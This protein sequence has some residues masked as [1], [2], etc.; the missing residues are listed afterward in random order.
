MKTSTSHRTDITHPFTETVRDFLVSEDGV[1]S[2]QVLWQVPFMLWF[3]Y[4]GIDV[5][6]HEFERTRLQNTLDTAVLAAA[7][8]SQ[9]GDPTE[10][11]KSYFNAAGAAASLTNV[12]VVEGLNKRRV[13]ADA[14]VSV[15]T[16]FLGE[17]DSGYRRDAT[18]VYNAMDDSGVENF[19]N[20]GSSLTALASGA[21]E[22]AVSNV[23][24]SLVVDV[25]GSM[26]TNNKIGK[27]KD[28]AEEFID[29]VV[30][31]GEEGLTTVSIVP[32][33][34]IVNLGSEFAANF[35][36]SKEHS[37][38]NC[39][40]FPNS[41]FSSV[42]ISQ[43]D[44]I[45][46]L[47]H[48][49]PTSNSQN[50]TSIPAPWCPTD[51]YGAP[52]YMA[53]DI[54]GLKAEVRKLEAKGATAI[55]MGMKWGVGLL[56]PSMANISAKM[57]AAGK[58]DSR[59][60]NRPASYSDQNTLKVVVLMTDGENTSQYDL[61]QKFKSGKSRI[62][63]DE[64]G[65]TNPSDDNSSFDL[66]GYSSYNIWYWPRKRND[67]YRYYYYP[68]G[69]NSARQMTNVEAF[70]RWPTIGMAYRFL[71]KPYYDRQAPLDAFYDYAYAYEEFINAGQADSNL[72]RICSAAKGKDVV[73]FTVAFEAPAAGQAAMKDC[74]SSESHY[75]SVEGAAISDVFAAIGRQINQLRL[76]Q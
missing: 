14:S 32:Y 63:L 50:T 42:A 28:A 27:L 3:G 76:I 56:D 13:S 44:E 62:W 16:I 10:V 31:E 58:I 24:V 15:Q 67:Q 6:M 52:M 5:M 64:R 53:N 61:K 17:D 38:S 20:F 45:E 60:A 8:L 66:R 29:A 72:S 47:A 35:N 12:E 11:V 65:N 75:F 49:D 73:I 36:L 59:A 71:E 22:E 39:P 30:M 33:S 46:R 70:A 26:A 57:A 41:A 69:G 23:E 68:D 74:A 21:A 40:R 4:V 25:S 34:G 37:Y 48:F 55:D 2:L 51:D 19:V 1:I 54:S 43:T 7:D 9:T 18:N